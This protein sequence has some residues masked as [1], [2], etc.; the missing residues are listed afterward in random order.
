[1]AGREEDRQD[2]Q[3]LIVAQ[4]SFPKHYWAPVLGGLLF[5]TA[6]CASY[7]QRSADYYSSLSQ[8]NYARASKSLEANKLLKKPRNRILY[9]LEK[10]K[11]EHLEG[12][13][14]ESNR[15]FN[16][17]DLLME[18][19]GR[20]AAS[21]I[22]GT[23]LN[24]MMEQY[25]GEDFEKYMVH[26]YKALNY[27]QLGQTEEAIVEARRI[28]LRTQAQEDVARKGR[29][30]E[31]AFSHILQGL[32]YERGSQVNDA[33]IA[34]RNAADLYLRKGRDFYGTAMPTQL[35]RDLLRTAYLNGFTEQ[36]ERYESLLDLRFDPSWLKTEGELVLFWEGGM[37]PVKEEV[38][39]FFNLFDDGRGG[40]YFL[41]GA[42]RYRVPFDLSM[43][44]PERIVE[45]LSFRATLPRY[46]PQAFPFR[47]ARLLD[48]SS[49]FALEPAQDVN[50]LA[51]ALLE[52]RR[53][54]DLSRTLTRVAIKKLAELAAK[55]KEEYGNN[56]AISRKE[57][58]RREALALG[59]KIF[60]YASEKADTRNWQSLPHTIYYARVPLRPHYDL[61][62]EGV[63]GTR[64]VS[65]DLPTGGG[66]VF[67][68]LCTLR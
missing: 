25:R 62:L 40:Y 44:R 5:L 24:P 41:D 19:G 15:S 65:L 57:R 2:G 33:F 7:H 59:L 8:G 50:Q 64:K 29:Y 48:G 67:R 51:L 32:I 37:A 61:E 34:Y 16:E 10:G 18:A 55:P 27:L 6:G 9:L 23:L 68:N 26:Y 12:R 53:L 54:R 3:E 58:D 47:G 42:G 39:L 31:D 21:L 13:Y 56:K 52:E 11:L 63:S 17:A 4:V 30:A 35:K 43:G 60:G 36:L 1:M 45:A 14:A 66:L 28:T 20:E 22:A 49:V 38:N 46:Q